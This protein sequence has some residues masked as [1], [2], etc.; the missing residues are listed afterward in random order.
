MNNILNIASIEQL[1]KTNFPF[2]KFFS[3]EKYK[4]LSLLQSDTNV[5]LNL[6]RFTSIMFCDVI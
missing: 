6:E 1:P 2:Y 5:H 3:A 4:L